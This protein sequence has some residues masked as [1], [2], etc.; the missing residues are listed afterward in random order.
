MSDANFTLVQLRY[1]VAAADAGS[2]T[3][4]SRELMVSQSAISTAIAQLERELGVQLLIRHHARGLTLT[5]AGGSFLA[6]LRSFLTHAQDLAEAARNLGSA[7]V[8]DLTVGCFS[9]LSPFHLPRLLA[10]FETDHPH[11]HVDVLEGEHSWLQA[12][13]HDGRCEL[14]LL[15]G[16]DIE[17]D[18][19]Y[20]VLDRVPPYALVGHEHR[21]A[22]RHSVFL[23]ELVD[24]PMVLL[25]LPHSRDYFRRV[26]ASL[27]LEPNVRHA[28]AGYETVR[29]LVA[30]GQGWSLLNQ[31][32]RSDRTYDGA[33]VA[34][35]ELADDV[36]PL[37]IVLARL[38]GV[39]L[40]SRAAAFS[41]LARQLYADRGAPAAEVDEPVSRDLLQRPTPA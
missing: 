21:L 11:V 35:L 4:A 5:R 30:H 38:R 41:R 17:D 28:S 3:A 40:T 36:A 26:L 22:G 15:Y 18:V 10:A 16:Y 8:G 14:A 32:P 33:R 20:D 1:F 39:Q 23:R 37:D 9:T 2:M 6:E 34:P 19:E 13:L 7:L 24:E 29:A 27:G 31:R 12:A 25:D